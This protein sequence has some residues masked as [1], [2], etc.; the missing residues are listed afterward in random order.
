MI[1]LVQS[2]PTL[3]RIQQVRLLRYAC[4]L[5]IALLGMMSG[6]TVLLPT[7]PARFAF[8]WSLFDQFAPFALPIAQFTASRSAIALIVGAF[9]L[10]TAFGIAKGKRQSWL[11]ATVLLPLSIL[12]HLAKGWDTVYA[13]LVLALWYG[14][15]VGRRLFHVESDPTQLRRG[16]ALLVVGFLLLTCYGVS[17]SSQL[18]RQILTA[19]LP[20]RMIGSFLQHL[21]NGLAHRVI[22]LPPAVWFFRS[23]PW[24]AGTVLFTGLLVLLRPVSVRW[25]VLRQQERVNSVAH[26]ARELVGWYGRQTLAFFTLAPENLH[27]LAVDKGGLVSYRVA[28]NVAVALGDAICPPQ[29]FERVTQNF[30]HLCETHDWSPAFFQAQAEHLPVYRALGL[31]ALKIGEEALLDVQAF[32]LSGSAMANVRSSARRAQREG[33]QLEW[34]EGTPSQALANRLHPLSQSWLERKAGKNAAELGFSMGRLSELVT[35]ARRADTVAE[36]LQNQGVSPQ[37]IP[38][39]M[40][41]MATDKAGQM[42]AFVTFTPI[43]GE[44][45]RAE[46]GSI[47]V[48][49]WGWALD[50][51]RRAPHAPPGVIELLL[52][53]AL[54]RFR[55]RD[56]QVLSLG[57][58]ALADTRQEMT[59]YQRQLTSFLSGQ[60]R[61]L[62]AH[63]SLFQFKRKFHPRWESRYLVTA[64]SL[65][66]LK[67]GFVLLRLVSHE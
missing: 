40:L 11:I 57:M 67:S 22:F 41:G 33:V 38:R 65:S 7:R 63:H 56:A 37:A 18:R 55:E 14:F 62:G 60:M 54:E 46:D 8:L 3:S 32:T 4:A 49:G 50:L 42:C 23:L 19:S 44:R 25:W 66:L 24:L 53:E 20:G 16:M 51:M 34:Y 15:I 30:L 26:R 58:V 64:T 10:C 35:L 28:G 31:Q 13:L 59:H 39:F 36:A 6:L 52:S 2:F 43:Y 48:Q 5:A 9:L 47:H 29:A 61:L 45:T 12:V 21:G 1:N 17:D 27:Y